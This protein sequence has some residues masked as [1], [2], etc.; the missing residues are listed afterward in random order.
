MYL[1]GGQ[2]GLSAPTNSVV[3]IDMTTGKQK[4][5]AAMPGLATSVRL[6]AP[7]ETGLSVV[8]YGGSGPAARYTVR[9]SG[10]MVKDTP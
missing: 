9:T 4:W 8:A 7:V 6:L 10:T 3:A 1:V 2:N 5:T